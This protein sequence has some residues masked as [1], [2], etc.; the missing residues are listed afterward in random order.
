VTGFSAGNAELARFMSSLQRSAYV[1]DPELTISKR[2]RFL[3]REAT[4]FEI[5]FDF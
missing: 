3:D 2:E 4:R 5:R 1:H